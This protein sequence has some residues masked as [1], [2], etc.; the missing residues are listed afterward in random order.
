MGVGALSAQPAAA[1]AEAAGVAVPLE[2]DEVEA[3]EELLAAAELLL[4]L[5]SPLLELLLELLLLLL[6]LLLEEDEEADAPLTPNWAS[7]LKV[8]VVAAVTT[9]DSRTCKFTINCQHN[10]EVNLEWSDNNLP[11][12]P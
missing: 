11:A 6:L 12:D 2:A 8:P 9:L 10:T 5:L 1:A 7:V 3:E 4:L